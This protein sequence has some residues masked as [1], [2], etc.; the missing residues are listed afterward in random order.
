MYHLNA[1]GETVYADH[2]SCT[3]YEEG[4]VASTTLHPPNITLDVTVV[5]ISKD[6]VN[7]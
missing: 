7:L 1:I 2:V 6:L 4:N 5:L 3:A